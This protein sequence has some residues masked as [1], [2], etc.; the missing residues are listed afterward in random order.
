MARRWKPTPFLAGSAALH[1][2]AAL[3][4]L[5]QPALW[6]WAAGAVAANHALITAAGLW[7]RSRALGPNITRLPLVP[8]GVA[9]RVALTIDDGPDPQVTPLVLDL[10]AEHRLKASFFLIG[11]RAERHP[12]L[13]RAIV[14][15]GHRAARRRASSAP[16][17]GCAI[18]FWSRCLPAR[19]C[20]WRAGHAAAT[21][22]ASRAPT[23]CC[24]A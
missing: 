1:G 21:T 2:A 10:L 8:A 11:H 22:R 4:V 23:G 14:Q 24:S 9:G 19:A 6:P 20:N 7:P 5:A 15:Q 18:C 13:C 17:R 3:G 12:A 16:R